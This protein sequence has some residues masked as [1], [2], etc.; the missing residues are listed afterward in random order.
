MAPNFTLTPALSRECIGLQ[1]WRRRA[2]EGALVV[3]NGRAKC[4]FAP[5][6]NDRMA[7]VDESQ[8]DPPV[9]TIVLP[10]RAGSAIK[11]KYR[12][13]LRLRQHSPLGLGDEYASPKSAQSATC[14]RRGGAR[15]G[16]RCEGSRAG[17]SACESDYETIGFSPCRKISCQ[18][19]VFKVVG[20]LRVP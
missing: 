6:C 2:G 3:A 15:G 1:S 5:T 11:H 19:D 12:N 13:T 18:E 16:Q 20:T 10:I 4:L 17:K 9:G 8:S 14:E 7:V